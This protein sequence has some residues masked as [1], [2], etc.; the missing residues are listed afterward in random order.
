LIV[1][2]KI[3]GKIQKNIRDKRGFWNRESICVAEKNS[4]SASEIRWCDS[5]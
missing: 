4:A 5:R 3:K 1:F 2:T